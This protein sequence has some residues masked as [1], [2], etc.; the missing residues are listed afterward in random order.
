MDALET[1]AKIDADALASA[2][3]QTV[4]W[5]FAHIE[6]T[7]YADEADIPSIKAIQESFFRLPSDPEGGQRFRAYVAYILDGGALFQ[8]DT[9]A[10][11][12]SAGYRYAEGD[13]IRRFPL[14]EPQISAS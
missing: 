1:S 7:V 2:V 8:S 4:D 6:G 5:G 14:L 10:Y 9:S 3:K 11:A 12:P 13:K